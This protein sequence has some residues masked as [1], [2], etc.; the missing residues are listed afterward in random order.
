MSTI[1]VF[2]YR[3]APNIHAHTL[4]IIATGHDQA[5]MV[6]LTYSDLKDGNQFDIFNYEP[7]ILSVLQK[8]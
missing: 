1:S 6:L 4:V 5:V 2:S 3:R 7:L 8:V